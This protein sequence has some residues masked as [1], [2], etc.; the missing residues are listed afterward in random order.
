MG[1]WFNESFTLDEIKGRSSPSDWPWWG[2]LGV[3]LHHH[4]V[5]VVGSTEGVVNVALKEPRKVVREVI[6][7]KC[8]QLWISVEDRDGF[9]ELSQA[10]GAPIVEHVSFLTVARRLQG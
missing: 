6:P 7:S 3:K 4:G 1:I 2:G 9:L 5:G 10:S 8:T